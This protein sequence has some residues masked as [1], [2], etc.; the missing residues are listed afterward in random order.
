MTV[1]CLN[2]NNNKYFHRM[3]GIKVKQPKTSASL[4]TRVVDCNFFKNM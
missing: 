1:Y 2:E 3:C 4:C